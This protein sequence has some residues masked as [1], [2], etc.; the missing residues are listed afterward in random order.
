MAEDKLVFY[1]RQYPHSRPPF[2]P[3]CIGPIMLVLLLK[4]GLIRSSLSSNIS[5]LSFGNSNRSFSQKSVKKKKQ[6][7]H[8][9]KL[10]PAE[11]NN[12][13]LS[14]LRERTVVSLLHLGEQRF[15]SEPGGYSF[16]NWMK[17]FN[18]LLDDF[19]DQV[20]TQNL[21]K[22]YFDRRF[23]LT[24]ALVKSKNAPSELELDVSKLREEHNRITREIAMVYDRQKIEHEI[25]DRK[26]KIG[27]LEN[28]KAQAIELLEDAKSNVAQKKKQIADSK[29]LLRRFFGTSSQGDKTPLQTLEARVV[30][31]ER[32]VELVE[33]KI[34]EQKKKI[35]P[36]EKDM[37]NSFSSDSKE[38]PLVDLQNQLNSIRSKLEELELG[39]TEKSQLLEER[40]EIT[41]KMKEEISRLDLPIVPTASF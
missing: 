27:L 18:L 39:Q 15:S 17:S 41:S 32:K 12:K 10:R 25:S 6:D 20:G 16:E 37:E 11:E 22:S 13:D 31:M 3:L 8:R 40:L 33:K 28:E 5:Q 29:K 21:P 4:R 34:M 23:E 30:D 35:E 14:A 26:E 36:Y 38:V 9:H 7:F 1:F 24:S 2:F 19:E